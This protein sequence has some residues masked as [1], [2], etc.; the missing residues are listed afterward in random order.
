MAGWLK[1]IHLIG[2]VLWV[3]GLFYLTSHL[4]SHAEL[5]SQEAKEAF[6]DIER[7][8]YYYVALPGFL[9]VLV[10]G[11][12]GFVSAGVSHYL[13]TARTWGSTFHVKLTLVFLLIVIDQYVHYQM[14]QL[15]R[16]EEGSRPL[17]MGL[18]GIFG[19]LFM[20]VIFIMQVGWFR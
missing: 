3:G 4:G 7:S 19:L 16:G 20:L 12:F 6:R 14:R 17:F 10:T 11:L 13:D 5:E 18:H 15:H 8:A 2:M 9:I 1:A